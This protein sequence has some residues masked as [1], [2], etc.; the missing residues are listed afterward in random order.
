MWPRTDSP[1]RL[2]P[3]G[4]TS[5]AL[6]RS[7]VISCFEFENPISRYEADAGH[8]GLAPSTSV[9]VA[10]SISPGPS[11]GEPLGNVTGTLGV[12]R[13]PSEVAYFVS[14]A[15]FRGTWGTLEP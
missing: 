11:A 14:V 6:R 3:M 13:S 9:S 8:G 1:T 2:A 4:H 10:R 7:Y 12:R 5:P 15:D